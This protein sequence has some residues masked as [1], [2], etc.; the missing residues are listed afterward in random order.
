MDM[1]IN[2]I[3]G[4]GGTNKKKAKRNKAYH[5]KTKQGLSKRNETRPIITKRHK[6]YQSKTNKAYQSRS[7]LK[8]RPRLVAVYPSQLLEPDVLVL[9][10]QVHYLNKRW[11]GGGYIYIQT[12]M[13]HSKRENTG[14]QPRPH[15]QQ[16][17]WY[18]NEQGDERRARPPYV[19]RPSAQHI[20][21]SPRSV[22]CVAGLRLD[23]TCLCC[24]RYWAVL[25]LR[26]MH[27]GSFSSSYS[28]P[29]NPKTYI[30]RCFEAPTRD[31]K[32]VRLLAAPRWCTAFLS[33][34]FLAG[35]VSKTLESKSNCVSPS[36]PLSLSKPPCVTHLAARQ[37]D[38]AHGLPEPSNDLHHSISLDA[39]GEL[40]R[41]PSGATM[42]DQ[43]GTE[44][45]SKRKET[46]RNKTKRH[47]TKRNET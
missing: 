36:L 39:L 4:R 41:A 34:P 44:A 40:P 43:N 13:I 8:Q 31:T 47:E 28:A 5:S 30:T 14:V 24:C 10:L 18:L 46:K 12:R 27:G 6:A 7:Y 25:L 16:C 45:V 17:R 35:V 37:S 21:S 32:F 2:S 38:L 3:E 15:P 22:L 1:L 42:A 33:L 23:I 26:G 11:G 20:L 19:E 29:S 9:T